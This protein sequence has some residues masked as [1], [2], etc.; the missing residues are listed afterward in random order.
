M[1]ARLAAFGGKT[2]A[3]GYRTVSAWSVI[4]FDASSSAVSAGAQVA[5]AWALVAFDATNW[6]APFAEDVGAPSAGEAA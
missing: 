4:A 3:N 6:E 5:S 1:S 2:L